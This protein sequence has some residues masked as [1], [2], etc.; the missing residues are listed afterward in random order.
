MAR[1]SKK[2]QELQ[3]FRKRYAQA[4]KMGLLR[5]PK[6]ARSV[7]PTRYMKTKLNKISEYLGGEYTSVKVSPKVAREY[8]EAPTSWTPLTFGNRVVVPKSVAG[9]LPKSR[10]GR[11]TFVRPLNN[12]EHELIPIPIKAV[13]V[14]KMLDEIRTSQVW[15]LSKRADE[16]FAFRVYG[17]ASLISFETIEDLANYVSENYQIEPNA[18]NLDDDN[19]GDIP[20][21][22][23]R[24]KENWRMAPERE[25]KAYRR[26]EIRQAKRRSE[27]SQAQRD[28]LNERDRKRAKIYR[29][30][31]PEKHQEQLRKRRERLKARNKKMSDQ[32]LSQWREAERVKKKIARSN[33][34]DYARELRRKKDRE[35]K[36]RNR[37]NA[38]KKKP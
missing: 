32:E 23:Y 17:N 30:R 10:G 18:T 7:K 12:G 34:D 8:R 27:M 1:K 4:K 11:L 14:E 33:E 21:L 3:L 6:D 15:K 26:R 19:E 20:L 16:K 2:S 24:E 31:Y 13:T 5:S 29:E 35:A 9:S 22:I 37:K 38:K 36:R 28:R 25:R